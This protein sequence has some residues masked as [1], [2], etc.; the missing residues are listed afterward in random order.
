MHHIQ[1]QVLLPTP[2]HISLVCIHEAT[3]AFPSQPAF[4]LGRRRTSSRVVRLSCSRPADVEA[5][6]PGCPSCPRLARSRLPHDGR[7]PF[8]DFVVAGRRALVLTGFQN[9]LCAAIDDDDDDRILRGRPTPYPYDPS[10]P[11]DDSHTYR[12]VF[13]DR[14]HKHVLLSAV[15]SASIDVFSQSESIFPGRDALI[16]GQPV[17][18]TR[19]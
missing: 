2:S 19:C 7:A 12:T 6:P 14:S 8:I 13:L 3:H 17:A 9:I 18:E 11:P 15:H 4:H 5:L 10:S 1:S 16:P